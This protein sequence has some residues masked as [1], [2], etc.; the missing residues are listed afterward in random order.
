MVINPL[1]CSTKAEGYT[2][3][4][5]FITQLQGGGYARFLFTA[6]LAS[7]CLLTTFSTAQAGNRILAPMANS[8]AEFVTWRQGFEHDTAGW[9]DAS[10]PGPVGWCGGIEAVQ[11]R[12]LEGVAPAPS[13]GRGYATVE[14]G[15]CNAFWDMLASLTG[16]EIFGAPY[17]PGPDQVLYSGAWPEAGYVTE[18]D[19]WLDP[20]WS[21]VYQGNFAW[22]GSPSASLVQY[23]ATIFPTAPDAEPFHTGPHYFVTVDAAGEGAL[24]VAGHRVEAAGW[25]TFRFV[26][27]DVAGDVWVDFELDDRNGSNLAVIEGLEPTEL[28]GPFKF[29]YAGQPPTAEYGSGHVWFYDVAGGLKLPIDEHR[30]RRGR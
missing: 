21:G 12:G 17:G 16:G 22:A 24:E 1:E 23:A 10:T 2:M 13:S 26:F 8:N 11:G 5:S 19:I 29:P 30:V 6:V 7:A 27:S 9:Y 4:S 20:D 14:A 15:D 28:L 18:L 3:K 25:Y